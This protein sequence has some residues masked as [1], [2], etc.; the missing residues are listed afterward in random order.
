M[1]IKGNR[2]ILCSGGFGTMGYL[3]PA[4]IGAAIGNKSRKVV[5]VFGD[6]SFQMSFFELGT[7]VQEY[8]NPIMILFNNSGLGMV[9]EIQRKLETKEY[10]VGLPKN[11]DF[12]AIVRA[13]GIEAYRIDDPDKVE[14][15]LKQ[16][17][18]SGKPQFLEFIV[19]D[20][21]ST[22]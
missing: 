11:P 14:Q 15:I 21:E 10:G 5:G 3:L 16:A 22:L 2:Q 17:I 7:L 4:C 13:Y 1:E 12:A 8:V 19:S 20:K 9:R 18:A 6:G